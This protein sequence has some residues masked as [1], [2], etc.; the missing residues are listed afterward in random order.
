MPERPAW[1]L[2]NLLSPLALTAAPLAFVLSILGETKAPSE[3]S[4][5]VS[6]KPVGIEHGILL[7][8]AKT[9]KG[10]LTRETECGN[11]VNCDRIRDAESGEIP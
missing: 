1:E 11:F 6:V 7:V 5:Q 4:L 3:S 2:A 8:F 9:E 10:T